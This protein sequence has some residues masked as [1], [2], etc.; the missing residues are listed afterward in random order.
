MGINLQLLLVGSPKL[1]LIG[2]GSAS[3]IAIPPYFVFA[4]KRWYDSLL[5][6]A[7][8]GV[9]GTVSETGWSNAAIFRDFLQNHFLKFVPI[10]SAEHPILLLMDGHA[11]HVSVGLIDWAKQHHII[12]FILP[13]HTFHIL[14]PLDVSCYGPLQ[15][16]YN[17]ECHKR[18]RQSSSV[19][20][21]YNICEIA[22]GVYQKALSS[23]NLVSG[24]RKTGIFPLNSTVI[25]ATVLMPAEI[26]QTEE[27]STEPHMNITIT[28][29]QNQHEDENNL[30]E[31]N[32]SQVHD[33]VD[34]ENSKVIENGEP[35]DESEPTMSAATFF[36]EKLN[37]LKAT[38][39]RQPQKNLGKVSV[40]SFPAKQSQKR[41]QKFLLEN[42]R[43]L[44]MKKDNK[45]EK[46]LLP[47]KMK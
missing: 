6:G 29:N 3:G 38:K 46:N 13:S 25:D 15:K 24:F 17:H 37:T 42:M 10:N 40:A 5:E 8:P 28:E 31:N 41:K 21:R 23:E 2:C 32:G 39:A 7:T 22:C 4:G 30:N 12:L 34:N 27:A 11:T 43:T 1:L 20:T 45:R 33:I 47:L 14:Q 36:G 19:I 44:E 16:M 9:T 18:I 35:H 26:F